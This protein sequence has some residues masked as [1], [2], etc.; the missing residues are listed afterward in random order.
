LSLTALTGIALLVVILVMLALTFFYQKGKAIEIAEEE[1]QRKVIDDLT[2]MN[3]EDYDF[4]VANDVP[5]PQEVHDHFNPKPVRQDHKAIRIRSPAE[6]AIRVPTRERFRK[7]ERQ[8]Q[9]AG[10]E[11]DPSMLQWKSWIETEK[12]RG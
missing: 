1:S 8:K 10:D 5:M 7:G 6:D 4:F 2:S 3:K 9:V 12:I 11:Y